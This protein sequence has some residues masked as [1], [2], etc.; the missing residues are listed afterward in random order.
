MCMD[1]PLLWID[2]VF[3]RQL[4]KSLCSSFN[5]VYTENILMLKQKY[6]WFLPILLLIGLSSSML[7]KKKMIS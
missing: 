4:I 3:C 2:I 7:V 5:L 1:V 6:E